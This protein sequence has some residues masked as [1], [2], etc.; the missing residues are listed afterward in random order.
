MGKPFG[1]LW[2]NFLN[3]LRKTICVFMEILLYSFSLGFSLSSN[4][5]IIVKDFNFHWKIVLFSLEK[6]ADFFGKV[7]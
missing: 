3:F 4:W 2:E 7:F 6:L 1:F 5:K